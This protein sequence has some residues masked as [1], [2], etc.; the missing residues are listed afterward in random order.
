MNYYDYHSPYGY[1]HVTSN[2]GTTK[3]DR[4]IEEAANDMGIPPDLLKSMVMKES[5]GDPNA[6]GD[7][8]KSYGLMQIQK[9]TWEDFQAKNRDTLPPEL[10]DASYEDI[11]NDPKLNLKAGAAMM[12]TYHDEWMEKGYSSDDAWK[13]ALRQYNTGSV[14]NPDDLTE[15][16]GATPDYV[17]SIWSN[18]ETSPGYKKNAY[19]PPAY[20]SNDIN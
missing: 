6:V 4:D 5:G 1:N 15:A 9:E 14:P 7:N 18:Y 2:T 10:R 20:D 12:K 11:K 19:T 17:D 8:G 16:G 13:L 3:W